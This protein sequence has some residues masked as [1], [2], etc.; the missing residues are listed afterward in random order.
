[1]DNVEEVEESVHALYVSRNRAFIE[2]LASIFGSSSSVPVQ[3]VSVVVHAV[4][5]GAATVSVVQNVLKSVSQVDTYL[6][7]DRSVNKIPSRSD[8][9]Y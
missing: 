5:S 4:M 8:V 7:L 3:P 6:A 9:R 1:M 2:A